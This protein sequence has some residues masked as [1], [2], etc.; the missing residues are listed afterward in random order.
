MGEPQ[1]GYKYSQSARKR[2]TK[3]LFHCSNEVTLYATQQNFDKANLSHPAR[4][5]ILR[6]YARLT[7][8]GIIE[9]K[10]A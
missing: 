1:R 9:T 6:Y 4:Y 10:Q 7:A 5:H 2:N 3:R 8:V